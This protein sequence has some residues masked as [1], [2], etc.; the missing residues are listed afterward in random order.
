MST[1]LPPPDGGPIQQAV[2]APGWALAPVLEWLLVEGRH[3][4]A[5]AP[6]VEGLGQ[7]LADAGAPVDR[8]RFSL[9]TIHPL[10]TAYTSVWHRDRGL[11]PAL[12]SPHGLEQREGYANSPLAIVA[13]TRQPFRRR[14][15]RDLGPQDHRLLHDLAREGFTDYL[16]LPLFFRGTERP[17]AIV[18]STRDAAGF[19]EGDLAKFEALARVTAPLLDLL[20]TRQVAQAVAEAYI[21]PRSGPLVLAGRI[22]RG[23][24]ERLEA[25]IWFSDLQGWSRLANSLEP[26]AAVG[27]A[28]AYFEIVEAAITAAGGEVLKLIGDAVL[29]IFTGERQEACRAAL[30]AAAAA[31]AEALRQEASFR[32][33]IG[34]HWGEVVMGNVGSPARLDFTVMGQAVN[35]AARIEKL[36]RK[37]DR[38]VVCSEALASAAG[39]PLDDLGRHPVAG[40]DEPV[41][42]FGPALEPRP[43]GS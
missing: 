20:R 8:L 35:L 24:V 3:L 14:L 34:L 2:A 7:R 6:L 16:V 42:V 18:V 27:I 31:Q 38:A 36:T 41:G 12:V 30:A 32:F 39:L 1:P 19:A 15:D 4:T 23:D 29:A 33:G 11:E 40:W 9:R 22:R 21:G 26:E 43:E 25:A 17:A 10:V 37:L 5:L 28:N 13:Q